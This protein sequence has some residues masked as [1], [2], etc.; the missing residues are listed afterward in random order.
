[1]E[2]DKSAPPRRYDVSKLAEAQ[3]ES[4]SHGRV[5]KNLLGI[6][7]KREMNRVEAQEQLRAFH[8]LIRIYGRSHRFRATDVCRIHKIWLGKVYPWAGKY[9]QVNV[10]KGDL[11]FATAS[12]IPRLM[13]EFE[14]GPLREFTPCRFGS[15]EEIDRA[16]AVVHV[17][18]VLIHPFREGN[19]RVARLIAN[20]MA[21]Q[22]GLPP[23]DFSALR[24]R[25]KK[26]YFA[27][28]QAGFDR[29]YKLMEEIFSG[30]I[31]RSLRKQKT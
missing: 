18:L 29:D 10:S 25:K 3:Y 8:E 31:Q 5:L 28:I 7:H 20:L 4:G 21:L 30:L 11:R 16:L 6:R 23:F 12:Q 27:A 15:A 26:E 17:E 9:R 13:E 22:A 1:M 19:G 14:D 2:R 24:G